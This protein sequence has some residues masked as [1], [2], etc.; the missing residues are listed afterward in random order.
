MPQCLRC[1]E[2]FP[3]RLKID[4][5]WKMLSKRK[6]CLSCSP[7]K[8]H[9]TRPIGETRVE[10]VPYGDTAICTICKREY[11]RSKTNKC[12]NKCNSCRVNGQRFELKRKLVDYKGGKCVACGYAK[13]EQVLT[14]HHLDPSTKEFTIGGSHTLSFSRLQAEVDKCVLLC[15]NCHAELHAGV[16]TL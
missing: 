10:R 3:N 11:T 8:Q 9:N 12:L 16:L 6:Y 2:Y 13:C 5:M 15:M 14:F 7:Y 4:G 1:N